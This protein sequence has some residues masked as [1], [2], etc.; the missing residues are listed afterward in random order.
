[1]G[2]GDFIIS[3]LR[4]MDIVRVI[5]LARCVRLLQDVHSSHGHAFASIPRDSKL[6]NIPLPARWHHQKLSPLS[7]PNPPVRVPDIHGVVPCPQFIAAFQFDPPPPIPST[8]GGAGERRS[9]V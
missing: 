6:L 1:M 8:L 2:S 4:S 9:N 7:T 3:S 5:P